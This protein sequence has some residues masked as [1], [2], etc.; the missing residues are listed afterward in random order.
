[1]AAPGDL[2]ASSQGFVLGHLVQG[3]WTFSPFY[4]GPA[5][6]LWERP[7]G[8]ALL[9]CAASVAFSWD[10]T[11]MGLP[12][13]YIGLGR[14]WGTG[15]DVW[16]SGSVGVFQLDGDWWSSTLGTPTVD[17]GGTGPSDLWAATTTSVEHFDGTEWT[18]ST[19]IEGLLSVAAFSSEVWAGGVGGLLAHRDGQ[20]QWS[21]NRPG[22]VWP[23]INGV[24]WGGEDNAWLVA[25]ENTVGRWDGTKWVKVPGPATYPGYLQKV[26]ASS[27]NDAWIVGGGIESGFILHWDG[28]TYSEVVQ[29]NGGLRHLWAASSNDLWA[30]GDNHLFHW[31]GVAWTDVPYGGLALTSLWGFASN[32]VWATGASG[33]LLHWDGASLSVHSHFANPLVAG[34]GTSASDLWVATSQQ[35]VHWDGSSWTSFPLPA[36]AGM[37]NSLCIQDGRPWLA[38][39]GALFGFS[40]GAWQRFAA[41]LPVHPPSRPGRLFCQGT[42]AVRA[43]VGNPRNVVVRW[44][45]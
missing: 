25:D 24:Y 26:W 8:G 33:D 23:E 42:N 2:W 18:P 30:A 27:P 41:E 34:A 5:R 12:F 16:L 15:L 10:G 39:N 13:T 35:S 4:L 31:D 6:A 45:P 29:T 36:D 11:S 1:M 37:P 32:D 19:S 14:F 22:E 21:F 20:Q 3:T 38:T 17:L 40:A 7:D 9:V 44:D 43:L 28:S